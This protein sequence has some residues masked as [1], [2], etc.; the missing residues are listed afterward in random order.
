MYVI[1]SKYE[2]MNASNTLNQFI[3]NYYFDLHI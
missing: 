1:Y 2:Y 3:S